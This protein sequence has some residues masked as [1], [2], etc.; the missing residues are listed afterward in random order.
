MRLQLHSRSDTYCSRSCCRSIYNRFWIDL[1]LQGIG[2][3]FTSCSIGTNCFYTN[4]L[5]SSISCGTNTT[6]YIIYRPIDTGSGRNVTSKYNATTRAG[7]SATRG[8]NGNWRAG[9][10][11]NGKGLTHTSAIAI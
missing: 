10:N 6:C 7:S 3:G 5:C 9:C 4:R 8:C 1:R 11:S 2:I